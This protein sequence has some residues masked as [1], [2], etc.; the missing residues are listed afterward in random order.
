MSGKVIIHADLNNCYASIEVLHHPKLRGRPVAVGG[1]VEQR[2][3]II[4]AKNYEA[5]AYGIQVGHALWQA[6][7]LCPDL[8]ILPPDYDK[9]LRY[10]RLFRRI[11]MDYSDQVEPF[12]LDESWAD[13]TAS[14]RVYGS[15]EVIAD[16]IRERVRFELGVT[17]SV[18]VSFNKIFA[19]L[20][21]DIKK[22]DATT[23]ITERNFRDVVWP[24]AAGELLGVGRATQAKLKYYGIDT[25]GGIAT[26]EPALLQR[27]FGK[28]GLFLYT[29]ANGMDDSAVKQVSYEAA[30]KSVGN[31]STC[32]RDLENEQDAHIVFLNLAESVAERMRDLGVMAQTV[33]ISL[34]TNELEWCERQMA[35]P[36][37]SMIA[38]ELADTAMRLLRKHYRWEKPLR[39]IGIR[40]TNLVPAGNMRQLSVFDNEERRQAMEQL[41]YTIDDIRRRYGYRS[42]G[43][44]LLSTDEKLGKLDAKADNVI[45]PVGY[46]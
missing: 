36:L 33:Q 31:S 44:A 35:L 41:E 4:L 3:G 29:Y 14:S 34:R 5:K 39:S 11:L 12:G 21:S 28:W 19:K 32:P 38:T 15:G 27:W 16:T 23:V 1:S 8:I 40:G 17:A 2:H 45:H 9:Y 42:I 20:G 26:A 18:G 13:V 37:P 24:L 25:I 6:R 46:L 30:V 43:R 22:P 10:S 7:Q